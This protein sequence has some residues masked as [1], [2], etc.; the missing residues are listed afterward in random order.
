A[1]SLVRNAGGPDAVP[2]ELADAVYRT[3]EIQGI[4]FPALLGLASLGALGVAWWIYVRLATGGDQGLAPLAH[5]RFHDQLVWLFIV[6]LVLVLAGSSGT[7]ER[8]GTNAVVFMG[9]LYALRGAAVLIFVTGG[10]SLAGSALLALA[11]LFV[12][13]VLLAGAMLVGLGDTWFDLR[14]RAEDP[15]RP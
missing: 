11:L 7:L 4:V 5:F 14:A 12:A 1:L 9:A 6:G 8:A 2:P 3:V 15:A 13:P 10:L